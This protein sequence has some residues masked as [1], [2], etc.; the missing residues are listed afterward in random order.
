MKRLVLLVLLIILLRT[1]AFAIDYS[2]HGPAVKHIKGIE[3]ACRDI[4]FDRYLSKEQFTKYEINNKKKR[5]PVPHG[6]LTERD[7]I[8][9]FMSVLDSLKFESWDME[10]P[11]CVYSYIYNIP[12]FSPSYQ[13]ERHESD[14]IHG[15]A[16]IYY[17]DGKLPE[18]IWFGKRVMRNGIIYHFSEKARETF[19]N[20]AE[21]S[22]MPADSMQQYIR[23]W[24]AEPVDCSD[25]IGIRLSYL[26]RPDAAPVSRREFTIS[27]NEEFRAGVR[28]V[29][30]TREEITNK[31]KISQWMN[32]LKKLE[33]TNTTFFNANEIGTMGH[34]DKDGRF[35]WE[36]SAPKVEGW[37]M[38]YRVGARQPEIVWFNS[39]E[40]YQGYFSYSRSPEFDRLLSE[41]KNQQR[42]HPI[43]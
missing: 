10:N 27:A 7:Q 41:M 25:I 4:I 6:L 32:T 42:N 43:E 24:N 31:V 8:A 20:Y 9:G 22:Q 3:C 1:D 17:D 2:L 15:Y 39:E 28:H 18:I 5:R 26:T 29:E 11:Y 37:L 36:D 19:I 21:A 16:V 14:D 33:F 35:V 12:R 23:K 40:I 34:I 13:I 38:I 30:I